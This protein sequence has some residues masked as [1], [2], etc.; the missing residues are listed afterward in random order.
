MPVESGRC[1]SGWLICEIIQKLVLTSRSAVL[2]M[3][4]I[5]PREF[6]LV[7]PTSSSFFSLHVGIGSAHSGEVVHGFTLAFACV[8]N[9]RQE[10]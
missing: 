2:P 5:I 1:L 9:V 10:G 7:L 3:I 6:F 4:L 8:I